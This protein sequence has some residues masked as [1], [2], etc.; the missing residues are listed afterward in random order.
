[1]SNK[2]R[3]TC[4]NCGNGPYDSRTCNTKPCSKAPER[5][6]ADNWIPK[7]DKLDELRVYAKE[8]IEAG[9]GLDSDVVGHR[10]LEILGEK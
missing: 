6:D 2:P 4:E 10:I 1:M 8:L 7:A 5:L 9:I 3:K